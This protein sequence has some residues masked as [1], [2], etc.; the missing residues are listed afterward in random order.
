MTESQTSS[1]KLFNSFDKLLDTTKKAGDKIIKAING[2]DNESVLK[3]VNKD[4]LDFEFLE[5]DLEEIHEK[6]QRDGSS[7][8]GTHVN[9]EHSKKSKY[10]IEIETYLQQKD[11]TF[12]KISQIEVNQINNLPE[13]LRSEI[14]KTGK[15][16]F[17]IEN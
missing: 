12:T 14:E 8:F 9:I 4:C 10:A 16:R 5:R 6:L 17:K 13:D 15:V 1:E 2:E 3:S 11:E 7:I